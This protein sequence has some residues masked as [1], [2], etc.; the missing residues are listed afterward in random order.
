MVY[1]LDANLYFDIIA[2]T[3]D[4]YAQVGLAPNVILVGI[5]YRD[6]P[7]MDSLRN[8]DD[9]YPLAIPEYEMSTS[10]GADKFLSFIDHELIPQIDA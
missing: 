4:K 8:R 9:T 6:F 3:I 1:V 10:G 7:T 5:G 2:T